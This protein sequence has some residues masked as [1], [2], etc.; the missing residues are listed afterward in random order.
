LKTHTTSGLGPARLPT[1]TP[2][3][4]KDRPTTTEHT[5]ENPHLAA[6]VSKMCLCCQARDILVRLCYISAWLDHQ[7]VLCGNFWAAFLIITI[8]NTRI[9]K[10]N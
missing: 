10:P 6:F 3:G 4:G 8:I 5:I 2:V 7:K 1:F 9:I